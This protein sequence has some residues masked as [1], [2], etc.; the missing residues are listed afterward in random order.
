M[1]MLKIWIICNTWRRK[2]VLE[3]LT[4]TGCIDSMKQTK[5]AGNL[6]DTFERTD[7]GTSIRK[8]KR[9]YKN[10]GIVENDNKKEA[11]E[12]WYIERSLNEEVSAYDTR[13]LPDFGN[14]NIFFKCIWQLLIQYKSKLFVNYFFFLTQEI[15]FLNSF[16]SKNLCTVISNLIP[17]D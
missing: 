2:E 12:T 4:V 1:I 11:E 7:C 14:I 6:L 13:I 15:H 10:A 17:F 16:Q 5:T 8:K 9:D 3:K